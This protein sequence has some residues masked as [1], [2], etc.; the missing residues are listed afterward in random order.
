[1][2]E[3]VASHVEGLQMEGYPVPEPQSAYGYVEAAAA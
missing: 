3:A 2:R 1:M